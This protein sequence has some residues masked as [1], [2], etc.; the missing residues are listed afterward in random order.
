MLRPIMERALLSLL[1]FV[2]MGSAA[3][4]A[5]VD[6]SW[7]LK[8]SDVGY[9]ST[10]SA[11]QATGG[12]YTYTGSDGSTTVTVSGWAGTGTTP[13][14]AINNY[15][16]SLVH[17]GHGLGQYR[18]NN[19]DSDHEIDNLGPDD[20]LVFQFSEPVSIA[21]YSFGWVDTDADSTLLAYTD[22]LS[23]SLSTDQLGLTSSAAPGGNTIANLVNNGWSAIGHYDGNSTAPQSVDPSADTADVFSSYWIIGAYLSSISPTLYNGTKH[24]D[25]FKLASIGVM[26]DKP[27][28][29]NSETPV[30]ASLSLVLLGLFMLRKRLAST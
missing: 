14:G 25:A 21:S 13:S 16:S 2:V 20:F 29:P 1:P 8:S 30:P 12:N 26:R 3:T 10:V 5:A 6:I 24:K 17:Y 27:G 28:T 18:S 11:N 9:S 4:Q 22:S 7:G 19:G 15:N 23:G